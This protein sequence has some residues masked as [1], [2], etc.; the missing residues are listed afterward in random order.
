VVNSQA[1]PVMLGFKKLPCR[2]TPLVVEALALVVGL[3]VLGLALVGLLAMVIG[4]IQWMMGEPRIVA[5]TWLLRANYVCPALLAIV[6][7]WQFWM[8]WSG[9]RATPQ[10]GAR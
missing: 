6:L 3:V 9:A 5:T 1:L 8:A 7:G 2:I 4:N 10:R